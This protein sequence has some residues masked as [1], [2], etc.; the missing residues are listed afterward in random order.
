MKKIVVKFKNLFCDFC[1]Y[2]IEGV[3]E[4]FPEIIE[5]KIQRKFNTLEVFLRGYENDFTK[6]I[7]A[8]FNEEGLEV[9]QII[10]GI[11]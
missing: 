5:Y 9:L 1:T 6:K 4:K 2:E 7:E 11:I 3:L 10:G 8:A